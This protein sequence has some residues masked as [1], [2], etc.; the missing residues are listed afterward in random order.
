MKKSTIIAIFISD[1]QKVWNVVTDN[2]NCSWRSDLSQII[3][4]SDNNNLTEY[5]KNGFKTDFTITLKKPYEQYE[6]DM[7]NK[8]MSGHWKGVFSQNGTGTRI[9]FTEE[10]EVKNS[11]MNLFV[12]FYLKKQQETYVK[13]LK[14]ALGE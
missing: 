13:D 4:S 5:T 9:E 12:K 14:K 8:N 6:F 7:K 3:V 11:I 2:N 10:V 1:V